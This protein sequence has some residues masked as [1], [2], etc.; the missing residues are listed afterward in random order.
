MLIFA[1]NK[2][3]VLKTSHKAF[4][5]ETFS[6]PYVYNTKKPCVWINISLISSRRSDLTL[7]TY[8]I[9]CQKIELTKRSKCHC[10][11]LGWIWDVCP[12]GVKNIKS[13]GKG[14][15]M[16]LDDYY[17]GKC[18]P[19]KLFSLSKGYRSPANV[20]QH[21]GCFLFFATLSAPF[22]LTSYGRSLYWKTWVFGSVFGYFW[23]SFRSVS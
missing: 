12:E 16:L 10:F 20:L 7:W 9:Y 19:S 18:S 14:F 5:L 2:K 8:A 3:H 1:I 4:N 11:M 6:S 17:T 23:L 21:F 22:V 15:M 13:I